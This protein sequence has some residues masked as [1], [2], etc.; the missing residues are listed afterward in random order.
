MLSTL[1]R[2][3]I[4]S[5]VL[6][7][8]LVVP[9]MGIALVYVLESQV[10]VPNLSRGLVGQAT[11]VA[12]IAREHPD[13]W[14]DPAH[15]QAFVTEVIPSLAARLML[16][17]SNGR[18]LASSDLA[19]ASRLGQPLGQAEPEKVLAGQASARTE[20]NQRL[21]GEVV[22]VWMPVVGSDHQVIGVVRLT[23]RLVNVY[24][25]FVRAR[26]LIAAVLAAG[27]VLG[28]AVGGVLAVNLGRPL[29]KVTQAI[30]QFASGRQLTPL[31]EQ[32]PEEV[33]LLS[34]AF[35]SLAER[36]QTLE[37]NRRQL[38]ANLVHE[39]GRPL[40]A[41]QSAIQALQGG[42]DKEETLRR[43]LLVGMGDELRRMRRLLD[44]LARL[45]DQVI[46][47]LE[48]ARRPVAL[49]D[50]LSQLLAPWR[51]AAQ[52]KGL[53]W[54][55]TL[56]PDLP[57]VEIDPDRLAQAVGNLLSNAIKYTP[58]G[59]TVSVEAGVENGMTWIHVSDTGPGIALAEQARI[60]TPHYR[61]QTGRRFSQGMGLG[62]SIARDLV[63]AHNGRLEV[64]STPGRGSRFTI[65]LPLN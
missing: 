23:Q 42:A 28:V 46:G 8:L 39:L 52:G 2:R 47:I 13:M 43:E 38:L 63:V 49:S 56:A 58:F 51:E 33:R 18:L 48:L 20:Y 5:H 53:Q 60:F 32:G 41:L 6:P 9:L 10:L 57:T 19:D 40:G 14:N 27:L 30:F 16:L 4:V 62:L 65:W 1:R 45:H 36:L 24:E 25:L 21:N 54:K 59:G 11:L 61:G 31:P 64:K 7:L 17:D 50:W 22:D 35:N 29:Q 34:R 37:Q 55:T 44:D 12:Q 15:A 3:L 26:Y